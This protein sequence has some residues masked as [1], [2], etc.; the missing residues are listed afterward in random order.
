MASQ[1]CCNLDMYRGRSS[2]IARLHSAIRLFKQKT[3][4]AMFL[5]REWD[6]DLTW[7]GL[8]VSCLYWWEAKNQIQHPSHLGT[9]RTW[10]THS[11][12][13]K[14]LHH[15][16]LSSCSTWE[17]KNMGLVSLIP[18]I[19]LGWL[20]RCASIVCLHFGNLTAWNTYIRPASNEG[21]FHHFR[22]LSLE[23]S[24]HTPCTTYLCLN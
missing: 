21:F 23:R 2:R 17:E 24:R 8:P 12:F 22:L 15:T 19:S 9:L 16:P 5:V 7:A 10:I 18:C 13:P 1:I 3:L 11:A 20:H 6:S 4:P 14:S